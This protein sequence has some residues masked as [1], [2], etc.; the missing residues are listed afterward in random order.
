MDPALVAS[1]VCAVTKG[2]ATRQALRSA[3]LSEQQVTRLVARGI[4][5]PVHRGV[6]RFANVEESVIS[7]SIAA[8]LVA[9][10]GAAVDRWSAAMLHELE[11]PDDSQPIS[12]AIPLHRRVVVPG[13]SV[14]R[15]QDL[16]RPDVGRLHGVHVT[17]VNRTLIDCAAIRTRVEL[18]RMVD[19]S[20]RTRRTALPL[21]RQRVEDLGT[22]GRSGAS[23]M[24]AVLAERSGD[25]RPT[26]SFER[27]IATL[28]VRSGLPRPVAQYAVVLA[29][30]ST[31]YIDL[32]YAP[33]LVGIETDGW[34]WHAQ[35]S[36]W[37]ADQE[38][39]NQ[40]TAQG[41]RILRVT[42]EQRRR[43]PATIVKAV[44]DALRVVALARAS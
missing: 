39:S 4:L 28:L 23:V 26:N 7:R 14:V 44:A 35:R 40:L 1:N 2:V 30:G 9:G 8:V 13:L 31:R 12:I 18:S 38:R 20:L 15:R 19:E 43:R 22:S 16:E 32:A 36:D 10:P 24:S 17:S 6:L 27:S 21:L 41:W 25:T 3:G 5:V 37:A 29:D 42:D 33:Q 34:T 11:A